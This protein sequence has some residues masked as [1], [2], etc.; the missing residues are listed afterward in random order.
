MKK[1]FIGGGIIILVGAIYFTGL[2]TYFIR[3]EVQEALPAV[4]STSEASSPKVLRTG[5]FGEVDFIHKGSGT[6]KIVEVDGKNILRIE[7]FNVV[8]GPDLYVYLS[9]SEKPTGDIKSLDKYISLGKLRGT[10]G[11]QNYE[12]S[13]PFRGYNTAIIWCQRFGVLFTYAVMK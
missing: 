3:T 8:S 7:D 2:Y 4:S 13:E 11:N 5:T 10:S 9:E 1:Y 6:A 12:I